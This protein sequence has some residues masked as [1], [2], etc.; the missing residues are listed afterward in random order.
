MDEWT[1]EFGS[2]CFI[3]DLGSIPGKTA[4]EESE[5][6][7]R[8]AVWA[9]VQERHCIV[10]VGSNLEGLRKKYHIPVRRVCTLVRR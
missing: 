10:E 3:T 5:P 7:G 1:K 9:P 6:L 2:R 4:G 8:Y